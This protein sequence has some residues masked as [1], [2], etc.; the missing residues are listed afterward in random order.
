MLLRSPE[1]PTFRSWYDPET[2]AR[3]DSYIAEVAAEFCAPVID[4][5]LWLE[6][7]DFYDSHHVLKRGADKFT[8]RLAREL[9]AVLAAPR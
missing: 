5:R 4:A 2:L 7:E 9:P 1:G 6:E 3:F 8:A